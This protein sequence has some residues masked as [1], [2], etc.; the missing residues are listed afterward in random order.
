MVNPRSSSILSKPPPALF[1]DLLQTVETKAETEIDARTKEIR[2][3]HN[4]NHKKMKAM[5]QER[6]KMKPIAVV[7]DV[8]LNSTIGERERESN[9]EIMGI[10]LFWTMGKY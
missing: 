1:L 6:K 8:L 10:C 3:T 7:A 9:M 4:Q 2:W 5:K